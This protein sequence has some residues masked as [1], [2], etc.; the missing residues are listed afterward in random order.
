MNARTAFSILLVGLVMLALPM[1]QAQEEGDSAAKAFTE[2]NALLQKG[3]FEGAQKA[4]GEAARAP[5]ATA[6]H[7]QKFQLVRR[8][9]A[10]RAALGREENPEKWQQ[11]AAAL[12]N[13]YYS[14]RLYEHL[15]ALAQKMQERRPSPGSATLVADALLL[16]ARD[17]EA[18]KALEG[19]AAADRTP[20]ASVLLGL[21]KGRL[22][23]VDAAKQ[24]LADIK[25]PEPVSPRFLADLAR[26]KVLCGDVEGGL[27]TLTTA[28][29]KTSTKGLANFKEFVKNAPEFQNLPADAGLAKVLA[30][31]SKVDE[32][33]CSGAAGCGSC[34]KRGSCGAAKK[35]EETK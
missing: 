15:L 16:L 2:G 8:V 3:D 14:H 9:L 29:E 19:I 22:S 5:G 18:E 23:K 11:T 25:V 7:Q 30:T 28:F 24:V 21:A 12:R 31:Q 10:M 33:G 4:F 17:A 27:A 13:F 34:P 35:P 26:L 20:Q 32:S 6:E 1:A